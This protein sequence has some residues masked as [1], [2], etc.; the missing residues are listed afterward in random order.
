MGNGMEYLCGYFLTF[1][2][3]FNVRSMVVSGKGPV[4]VKIGGRAWMNTL[5]CLRGRGM[6]PMSLRGFMLM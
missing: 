2:E 4:L 3:S 5:W 6:M 1:I